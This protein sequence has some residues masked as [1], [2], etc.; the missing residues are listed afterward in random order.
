MRRTIVVFFLGLVALLGGATSAMAAPASTS[1]TSAVATVG[2]GS[3]YVC[4]YQG[5]IYDG[6]P[7]HPIVYR[8]YKYG[9]YNVSGLVGDYTVANCQTG[10]AKFAMYSG[11]NGTG[12]I[13]YN[14]PMGY[15]CTGGWFDLTPVNSVRLLP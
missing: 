3:G 9:T 8:W 11:Y 7:N 2:C 14:G 13:L 5:D 12:N 1:G 10:G 4:I 6:S 15:N